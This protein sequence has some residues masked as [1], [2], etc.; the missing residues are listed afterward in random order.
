MQN[1]L[2][3]ARARVA[4][5]AIGVPFDVYTSPATFLDAVFAKRIAGTFVVEIRLPAQFALHCI[6]LDTV[7]CIVVDSSPPPGVPPVMPLTPASISSL[8][9]WVLETVHS[10]GTG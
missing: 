6:V 5:T 9:A 10:I 8:S 7:N 2:T 4:L 3:F 1:T